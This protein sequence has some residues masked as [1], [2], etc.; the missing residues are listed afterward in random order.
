MQ[1]YNH[2]N[3]NVMSQRNSSVLFFHEA[4]K[5]TMKVS[6]VMMKL[7]VL[8]TSVLNFFLLRRTKLKVSQ[9]MILKVLV[10]HIRTG[11]PK[12][13]TQSHGHIGLKT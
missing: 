2:P 4:T 11:R 5:Q 12:D 13:E 8:V 10:T 7:Q 6:Q 9:M 1:F 3:F